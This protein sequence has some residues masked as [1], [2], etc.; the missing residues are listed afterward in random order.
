MV[1]G[2]LSKKNP[3]QSIIKFLDFVA[4]EVFEPHLKNQK[5]VVDQYQFLKQNDFKVVYNRTIERNLVEQEVL[6]DYLHRRKK[7]SQYE[8]DGLV[9]TIDGEYIRNDCDNPKY[10]FAF[11]IQGEVAQVEVDHVKWNLSKSGKYKPQIFINPV[12]LSGVTI[13]S[14]TGFNA[15]YITENKIGCGSILI[16]TRSGDVIPHIIS[17][18]K[19][20]GDLNLPTQSRWDSVDLYYDLEKIPDQVIVKQMVYFFT[21]LDCSNCKDKTILKIFN[22]GYTSIESIIQARPEELSQIDGIGEKLATKL[23]TSIKEN[24]KAAGIHQLLAALNCFG[25]GIGL[26]K[27]QNIDLSNPENLQVKGLSEA[28]IKE[29]I[30]PVWEESLNRVKKIKKMVGIEHFENNLDSIKSDDFDGPFK[31]K[32][33]V[34]TGFRDAALEK[35]LVELGGKVTTAISK[36]STDLV[37]ATENNTKSSSKLLKAQSLGIKI[38]TK[39]DLLKKIKNIERDMI[40]PQIDYDDYGSSEEE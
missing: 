12:E 6:V 5:S 7:K 15:K 20:K 17:V 28:T 24:V 35:Q 40:K 39:A 8:I 16:I 14:V 23:S 2:Q 33:F 4:Y 21:S 38:T 3:D 27:I 37:V 19:G 26:R 36:K 1:S 29:K 11:K 34:F 22:S 25:E 32:V 18:V 31:D 9:V 13:S 30:L 10:S